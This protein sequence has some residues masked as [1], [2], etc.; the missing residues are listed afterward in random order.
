MIWLL[1]N[2]VYLLGKLPLWH[3]KDGG[4]DRC[5]ICAAPEDVI[6]KFDEQLT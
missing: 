1:N 5:V 4:V 2:K 3:I 6:A